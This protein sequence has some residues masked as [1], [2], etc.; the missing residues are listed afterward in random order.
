MGLNYLQ[1]IIYHCE[2]V[3]FD[4]LEDQMKN[5]IFNTSFEELVEHLRTE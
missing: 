1:F 4:F 5:V 2:K 3:L